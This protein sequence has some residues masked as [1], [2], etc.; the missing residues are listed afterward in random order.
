MR[1]TRL[2]GATVVLVAAVML[3]HHVAVWLGLSP[4]QMRSS[5]YTATYVASQAWRAHDGGNLYDPKVWVAGHQ[6]IGS[7]PSTQA[8]PYANPPLAAVVDAPFSALGFLT[9][10]RLFGLV[11]VVLIAVAILIAV[12]AAPWP[13]STPR[14]VK[15][16]VALVALAGTGTEV[17]LLQAQWDGVGALGLALAYVAW[18]SKRPGWAGIAIALSFGIT[19]PHLVLGLAAFLLARRERRA[20]VAA[21]VTTVGTV[22]AS[23]LLVGAHGSLG[24][25]QAPGYS[26]DVSPL[27]TILGINGLVFSNLQG[28]VIAV[29]LSVAA[30]A[31]AVALAALLGG[32]SRRHP[33]RLEI[34]LAGAAAL[35]LLAAPHLLVHDLVIL[36]PAL[37]WCAA[38][39]MSQARSERTATWGW[40]GL[41]L[42]WVALSQAAVVDAGSGGVGVPGR[43]VPWVLVIGSA[44]AVLASSGRRRPIRR[45]ESAAVR[46]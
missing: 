46:S 13:R 1:R 6:A 2:I 27:S 29:A 40:L 23:L 21:V 17:L 19:K 10:Y 4:T 22:V 34:G 30:G 43:L 42:A 44:A 3:G 32:V 20:T 14:L 11:Q 38:R 16:A 35:S 8:M 36:A 26:A 5:D 24:F 25:L 28:G 7:P 33:D 9:S 37:V 39:V 12:R 31:L 15:A 18:R 41:V 45:L